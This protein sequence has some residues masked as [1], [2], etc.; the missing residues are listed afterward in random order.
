[1]LISTNHFRLRGLIVVEQDVALPVNLIKKDDQGRL[2]VGFYV[3]L[4]EGFLSLETLQ[5]AVEVRAIA[6]D[7][8]VHT[9]SKLI[10]VIVHMQAGR[11]YY[12]D[13]GFLIKPVSLTTLPVSVMSPTMTVTPSNSDVPLGIDTDLQ[14]IILAVVV[15]VVGAV[16][17]LVLLLLTVVIIQAWY[18]K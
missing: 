8:T 1:M 15:S 7:Y 12:M 5:Q 3:Q 2:V 9:V 18:I 16:V 11:D 6:T 13:A 17:G 10:S 4:T 14:K